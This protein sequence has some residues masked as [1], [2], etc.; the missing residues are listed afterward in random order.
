V[1]AVAASIGAWLFTS[2]SATLRDQLRRSQFWVLEAQAVIVAGLTIYQWPHVLRV[3]AAR[4]H[5]LVAVAGAS[6]MAF[7]LAA[8]V[9]PR[10]S[11]IFTTSRSIRRRA[12]PARSPRGAT[13]QRW[14]DPRWAA[15]MPRR[16]N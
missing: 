8:F 15:R 16:R 5:H 1:A 7:V 9:A 14:V 2:D 11:R 10:T 3:T 13:L 6:A 12:E 4:R